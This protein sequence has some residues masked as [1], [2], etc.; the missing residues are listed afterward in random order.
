M[1]SCLFVL[2]DS[3]GCLIRKVLISPSE[4]Y[5][6]MLSWLDNKWCYFLGVAKLEH[7]A[8]AGTSENWYLRRAPR[9]RTLESL[10]G[11]SDILLPQGG[12][13]KK[14]GLVSDLAKK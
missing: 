5:M 1:Q 4:K 10:I 7:R 8:F 14:I 11:F 3:W 12:I 13:G 2:R 9:I 6:Q